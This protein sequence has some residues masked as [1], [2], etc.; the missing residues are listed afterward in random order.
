MDTNRIT[1]TN[2]DQSTVTDVET[3]SVVGYTVVSAP[4]GPTKPVRIPAGHTS[5]IYE[6][7]GYATKEY[8]QVQELI[9]FNREYDVYVSAP[10]DTDNDGKGY[11]VPVA[12]VT[13]A[14]IFASDPVTVKNQYL[15][16]IESDGLDV[17]GITEFDE[18]ATVYTY[19]PAGSINTIFGAQDAGTV[20]SGSGTTVTHPIVNVSKADQLSVN[21]ESKLVLNIGFDADDLFSNDAKLPFLNTAGLTFQVPKDA[22]PTLSFDLGKD[23]TYTVELTSDG[24]YT[25]FYLDSMGNKKDAAGT[26]TA[27]SSGTSGVPNDQ[28]VFSAATGDVPFF[29]TSVYQNWWTLKTNRMSVS[30]SWKAKIDPDNIYGTIYPKYP[31]TKEIS[32]SFNKEVVG[33]VI[34]MTATIP[35]TKTATSSKNIKGSLVES[36]VDGFGANIG[37]GSAL[38]KQNIIQVHALKT[39]EDASPIYTKTGTTSPAAAFINPSLVLKNGTHPDTDNE[40]GWEEA[41]HSEYDD[42]DL[43]FNN[44]MYTSETD[45]SKS[46]FFG[47]AGTDSEPVHPRAG[48]IFSLTPSE[49]KEDMSALDFGPNYWNICNTFTR[50]LPIT[51]ETIVSPLTGARAAMQGRIITYKWGGVAPM[52]TN[53][54]TLGGQLGISVRKAVHKYTR[55]ELDYLNNANYNPIVND[56]TY[57]IMVVGQKTCKPGDL[58]DWSYI[59]HVCSFL[60]FQ[61]VV[62]DNVM[63]PQIGKANNPYY[64][65]LRKQQVE[66]YLS[67]RTSGDGRIWAEGIVDTSTNEGINDEDTRNARRFK[68]VVKVKVDVFSEYVDLVFYNV[69][70]GTSLTTAEEQ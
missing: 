63:I 16:D 53:E 43:F 42:V 61:K 40:A 58:S 24:N 56:P 17:P 54:N 9:D 21:S 50:L 41:S 34:S 32:L 37:F 69:D 62:R 4:N 38:S 33:D 59:G 12:Y 23:G 11:Q 14:G 52:W 8:P 66:T 26:W 20:D 13:P 35:T 48:Y 18:G 6:I 30:V 36:A 29:T 67:Q 19:L 25:V 68:I 47:L 3:T 22:T 5:Q 28:I 60:N 10:Y 7:F 57:G 45:A 44:E 51:K 70:Q 64:R 27:A 65:A 15:E 1:I 55:D 49:V 46:T 31:T 39:F 2:V